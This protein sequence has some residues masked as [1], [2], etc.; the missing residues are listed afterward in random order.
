MTE[1]K[2]EFTKRLLVL[3]NIGVLAWVF[4]SA[5]A[6][7]FYNQIYGWLY[8]I[9]EAIFIYLILRRIGCGSCY[10]CKACTAGFGRIAGAFFGKGFVKKASV[11]KRLGLIIFVYF[12]L[13]PFP[14]AVLLF[15]ISQSFLFLK[16]LVLLLLWAVAA[17]SLTTWYKRST[18]QRKL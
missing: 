1:E 4:L 2:L 17:Y 8:L 7:I 16:V 3:G 12:F 10:Q 13:L 18:V 5:F 6:I 14:S 9:L 15:S 11:G